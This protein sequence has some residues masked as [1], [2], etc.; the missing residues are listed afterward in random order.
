MYKMLVLGLGL[1]TTPLSAQSVGWTH[2]K[3]KISLP[4]AIGEMTLG[5]ERDLSGGREVDIM[6]QY[7]D[8]AEPVT[9][10]VYRSSHPNPALWFERTRHA[11]QINVG[12]AAE[13]VAPRSFNFAGASTPNGL[14]EEIALPPGRPWKTTAVAIAQAGEW[15]VKTRIT[16]RT[17]D[18]AGAS[19]KMDRLLA[20][21]QVPGGVG[22]ALPLVVPGP[23]PREYG[24]LRG[25]PL[26]RGHDEATAAAAVMG[27]GVLAEA[28]GLA[29]LA[30]SPEAWCRAASAIPA[31]HASIY[32][33]REGAGW[34]ALVGDSGMA[35]SG[36]DLQPTAK[37]Y[38]TFTSNPSSVRVVA[39]YDS[40]A[41]PDQAIPQALP[42]LIGHQPGLVEISVEQDEPR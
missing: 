5:A 8:D 4:A 34:V 18:E 7:G 13:D 27:V 24:R 17:L 40:A 35:V 14:R 20:A 2:T 42:V 36:H 28:R 29:G 25:K 19:A 1:L 12:A 15:I 32:R 39:V 22:S 33:Q 37:G 10:Y 31:Q 41:D 23:C 3:S 11:M 26:S 9:V 21:F 6:V 38:A 16:S 30:A